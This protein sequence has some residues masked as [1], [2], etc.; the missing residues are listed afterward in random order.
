MGGSI[1]FAGFGESEVDSSEL[2]D[3]ERVLENLRGR[4]VDTRGKTGEDTEALVG[5]RTRWWSRLSS[6]EHALAA[7]RSAIADAASRRGGFEAAQLEL[8]H[9]GGSSPDNLFPACACEIQGALGIAP[10]TCEARDVSLACCSWLDALVLAASRLRARSKRWG[11]VAVGESIGTRLNAPTS[12]SHCLWGDGGG[13]VVI[14][15]DADGDPR[16]GLFADRAISDGRFAHWTRSLKIGTH[17]DHASFPQAD[18]SMLDHGKD[19]HK[20]AIRTVS[21]V[22]ADLLAEHDLGPGASPY[23][24]PHTSNLGMVRQIGKR[25]GIPE[26]RVLTRIVERGNTSSASIPIT[27]AHHARRGQFTSGD[28]LILA[29]FGGGMAIDVALYR[30]P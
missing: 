22:I 30:W 8:V 23:L 2:V 29:A 16:V 17:P 12:L 26:P 11:L 19:I 5:I 10:G 1:L 7:S 15:H 18:A 24:V 20:Y 4:G 13:A 21:K 28:V 25:L 6:T 14:E 3:N 9:S 27:L